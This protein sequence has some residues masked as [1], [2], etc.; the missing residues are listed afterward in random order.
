[1]DKNEIN[2]QLEL[3]EVLL[4]NMRGVEGKVLQ[5]FVDNIREELNKLD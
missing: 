1:M 3:M 4:D 5:K 2:Y